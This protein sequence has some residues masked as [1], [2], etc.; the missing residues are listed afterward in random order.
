MA[1]EGSSGKDRREKKMESPDLP[2]PGMEALKTFLID[3]LMAIRGRVAFS[4]FFYGSL[5]NFA[6]D[7]SSTL[8]A[9]VRQPSPLEK[10]FFLPE[11]YRFW[12]FLGR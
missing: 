12:A 3:P 5:W 6:Y 10:R 1:F 2:P 9:P 7:Q 11:R 8:R 4:D